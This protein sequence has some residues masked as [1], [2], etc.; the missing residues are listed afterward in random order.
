MTTLESIAAAY[1]MARATVHRFSN[2][3]TSSDWLHQPGPGANNAAWII[4]H[5][6]ISVHRTAERLGAKD[7]PAIPP[8]QLA[9]LAKT[10][11]PAGDQSG[12]A[13]V[14]EMR[15]IF[16]T[17]IDRVIEQVKQLPAESLDGPPGPV[18]PYATTFGEGLLFG[19]IHISMHA[20]QLTMI[21]RSLG[22]PPLA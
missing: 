14:P 18:P 22:R 2:D 21:R 20:G 11:Q 3:F 8:E 15:A 9:A 17:A 7:L 10:G 4:G 16:D 5:L 13:G 12:L 1:R 6:A 19:A